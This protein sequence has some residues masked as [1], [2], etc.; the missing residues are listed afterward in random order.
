MIGDPQTEQTMLAE[1]TRS[2]IE[3]A[4]KIY[5]GMRESLESDHSGEYVAIEPESGEAFISET[6][7][8]AVASARESH[9]SRVSH[10]IRIGHRAAFHIGLMQQ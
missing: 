3:K 8:G 6:F 5:E 10:T 2:I 1:D 9:P 4:K 7:D